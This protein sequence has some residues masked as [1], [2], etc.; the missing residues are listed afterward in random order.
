MPITIHIYYTGKNGNAKKFA[1][2]MMQRGKIQA[3]RNE[4]GI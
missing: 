1:E 4:E 3:I 2:E